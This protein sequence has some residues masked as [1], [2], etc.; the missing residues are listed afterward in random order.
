MIMICDFNLALCI[1][2][3]YKN[4]F[5]TLLIG[6]FINYPFPKLDHFKLMHFSQ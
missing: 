2:Y 5:D 6:L 3:I 4:N 1:T